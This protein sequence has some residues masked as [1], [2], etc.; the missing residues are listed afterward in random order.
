MRTLCGCVC[1][2]VFVCLPH[3]TRAQLTFPESYLEETVTVSSRIERPRREIGAAV[4]TVSGEE[5][6]SRGY[7]SI[8]D[9][10]RTQTAVGVSNGGGPGK[11]SALRIRGEES[12]RTLIRIDGIDISD[13]SRTQVGPNV[14]HVLASREIDR[15]A[16]PGSSPV[17]SVTRL[18]MWTWPPCVPVTYHPPHRSS[19]GL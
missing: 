3:S 12:Y 15:V 1:F 19:R 5:I 13:P 16:N 10:L 17:G 7:A 8:M 14:E 11:L 2:F 9:A 4:A 18:P 6:R